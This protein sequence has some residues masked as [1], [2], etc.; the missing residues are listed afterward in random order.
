MKRILPAVAAVLALA[1]A[2]ANAQDGRNPQPSFSDS[3]PLYADPYR[4]GAVVKV[5]FPKPSFTDSAELPKYSV[6]GTDMVEHKFPR[7]SYTG[8]GGPKG[9]ATMVIQAPNAPARAVGPIP[10]FNG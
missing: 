3:A 10:S 2:A 8:G 6:T 9:P 4:A 1:S 5:E 7:G